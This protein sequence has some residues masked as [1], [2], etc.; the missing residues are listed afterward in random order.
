[1]VRNARVL[2]TATGEID[3]PADI[4][5][6]GDTIVGVG[7]GYR[8]RA[9]ID[10]RGRIVAPGLIDTHLHVESSLVLPAAFEEGVLPRGTTTAICDPHEI[11]NVLGVAGVR[12]FLEAARHLTAMTLKVNLSSCVPATDLET[13]G[14]RL[15]AEDLL[16]LMAHPSALGLAE[17]MNFPGVLAKDPGLLAKLAAFRGRHVDG[18]APLL[19]GPGLNAY[20]AAG[21]RTDHECTRLDE[22]EEKLRRGMIV[23]IR[24][25]TIA[26]NARALAPLISER[27][28]PR[29]AF[30]TDDR[31]PLE[32]AGEGHVDAALRVAIRAGAP[33]IPVWRSATLAAAQAFGLTDRG[34]VAP[35]YRADLVLVDDLE[36]VAISG[37]V[38]GGRVVDDALL[39]APR[40]GMPE[41]VGYGSVRRAPVQADDLAVPAKG[42]SGPVI[43]AIPFSLLTDYLTLDMTTRDGLWVADPARDVLKLCVLERHGVNGNI[44]RGFVHGF[45]PVNGAIAS[46]IGHDSHNLTVCG[47]DDAD[48]AA[49]VNHLIAI[50]GGDVVVAGGRVLADLPL[51]VAGLM[52]DRGLAFVR[53][54]LTALRAAARAIGCALDEP[55][56]QLAFLPLPVIPHLKLTDRGYVAA[57]PG[58]GL[59]LLDA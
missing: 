44:G 6:C 22:A 11:A 49:A 24:E 1:V 15:E 20:L 34:I 31:N 45:G 3:L 9:E 5:V 39:A 13:A 14:G 18:H 48:M 36:A 54:R 35:G 25:G 32:I 30:C 12:Y 28:W 10:A 19:S 21:I 4:A 16:P 43:G 33:A 56:L 38:C 27:T 58:G 29:I 7:E 17:V 46:T 42:A 52:S 37:V 59:R 41:P 40:P 8:A 23:L 26:K 50:Q 55:L 2:S 57:G 47:S 53:E 51:P